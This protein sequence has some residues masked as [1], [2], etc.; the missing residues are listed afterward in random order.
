MLKGTWLEPL[1]WWAFAAVPVTLVLLV[2]YAV[3]QQNYREG[4][5]DPQIQMA[6]DAALALKSGAQ[7]DQVVPTAKVNVAESLSPWLAVY[8]AQGVPLLASGQLDGAAPQPPQG[9]FDSSSWVKHQNGTFYDQG[10]VLETRVTWQPG[11]GVRQAIVVV[12]LSGPVYGFVIAGRNMREVEQRIEHEG[13][14]VFAGWLA[15]LIAMLA[16]SYVAWWLLRYK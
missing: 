3:V 4:L 15:T 9:I 14:I 7:I 12:K 11:S 6:E 10:P 2:G 13:E 8:N 5:N 1:V 16:A